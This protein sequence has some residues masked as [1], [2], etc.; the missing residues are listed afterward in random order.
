MAA[1]STR[2]TIRNQIGVPLHHVDDELDRPEWSEPLRPPAPIL[3]RSTI[4]FQS[5]S[6]GFATGTEGRARYRIGDSPDMMALHWDN[7]Y[8]G[9]NFYEQSISGPYGLYFSGGK[10]DN[11]EVVYSLIPSDRIAVGG[12]LPSTHGFAPDTDVPTLGDGRDWVMAHV[13]WPGIRNVIDSGHPCPIGVA[14]GHLPNFTGLGHQVC[15]YGYQLVGQILTLWVYDPNSPL[16]DDITMRLDLSRTD[17][18]LI[19]VTSSINVPRSPICFFTQSYEQRGPV[20]PRRPASALDAFWVGPDNAVGTTWAN[21][22][23][24]NANWHPPFPI[25]QPSGARGDSGLAALTRGVGALDVFWIGPDGAIATN[26]ANPQVDNANWHTP[27]PITPA[28]AARAGSL[29]CAVTRFAGA[30]DAFWI[31]PDGA[32][33]TNWANPQVDNASTVSHYP[34]RRGAADFHI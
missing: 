19:N 4:W 32:V 7:P 1:R 2:V 8:W 18:Q 3:P 21:P 23:V 15:V 27:F 6:D 12:Y 17:Q 28:G 34:A 26:W 24:D 10:G 33:A 5:E 14:I 13:G 16:R 31:G 25:T 20:L 11:T 22:L 30:L 29:L 9:T